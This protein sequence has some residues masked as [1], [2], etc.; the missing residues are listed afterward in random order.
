LAE[1][2]YA[3]GNRNGYSSQ[4]FN[5]LSAGLGL[6]II[7]TTLERQP[8]YLLPVDQVLNRKTGG[9]A[10]RVRVLEN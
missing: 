1:E 10:F 4:K 8:W 3:R 6:S 7:L 9:C 2:N 5:R